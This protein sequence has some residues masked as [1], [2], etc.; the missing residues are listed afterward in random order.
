MIIIHDI[1]ELMTEQVE[2][3]V[4]QNILIESSFHASACGEEETTMLYKCFFVV[5]FFLLYVEHLKV[6]ERFVF[7]FFL[8]RQTFIYWSLCNTKPFLRHATHFLFVIASLLPPS[9]DQ[10]WNFLSQTT[11]LCSSCCSPF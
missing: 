11:Q 5:F 9:V 1:S 8:W 3:N 7:L 4:L 6:T 2:Q 10:I